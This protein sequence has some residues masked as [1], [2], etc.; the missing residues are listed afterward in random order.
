MNAPPGRS[1]IL[2]IKKTQKNPQK[3]HLQTL[4]IMCA[5][6]LC[7]LSQFPLAWATLASLTILPL[8]D[9]EGQG[10]LH[11]GAGPQSLWSHQLDPGPNASPAIHNILNDIHSRSTDKQVCRKGVSCSIFTK[12]QQSLWCC[13]DSMPAL[14]IKTYL[15]S[16]L[17]HVTPG[18]DKE[19]TMQTRLSPI[20]PS[21]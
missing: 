9:L 15:V 1:C 18:K 19:A 10:R 11:I 12:A 3:N 4:Q 14:Q 8:L 5:C 13:Q 6:S 16:Y 21:T 17:V 7:L 20:G 2:L